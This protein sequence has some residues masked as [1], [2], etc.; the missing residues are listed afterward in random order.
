[1]AGIYQTTTA[2]SSFLLNSDGFVVG[3]LYGKNFDRY[4]VEGGVV[5]SSASNPIWGG[6]PLTNTVA[7][8]STRGSSGEGEILTLAATTGAN[9]QSW[10]V[11]DQA[12]AG[13]I[14]PFSNVPLY[15]ANQSAN[16][17]RVG[18]GA[19]IVLPIN[20]TAVATLAGGLANVALFWDFTNNRVDT[21]GTGQLLTATGQPYQIVALNQNSKTVTFAAGPPITANWAAGGSVIIVRI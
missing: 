5:I 14:T 21:S 18:S 2:S 3:T 13:V 15:Y 12:S 9:I 17:V 10:C 4:E 16:F 11:F 1:M 8:P 6:Q 7:T 20:P 19:M